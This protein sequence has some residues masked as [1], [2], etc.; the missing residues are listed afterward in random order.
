MNQIHTDLLTSQYESDYY[1]KDIG[2][3]IKVSRG[4]RQELTQR[5]N[6][7][8]SHNLENDNIKLLDIGCGTGTFLSI[9]QEKGWRVSG[10]ELS[11]QGREISRQRIGKENVHSN[12]ELFDAD[13]TFDIIT[14]WDVIEHIPTPL[15]ELQKIKNLL[16]PNGLFALTTPNT[17]AW[18]K[19]FFHKKWR[20]F[21]A[22]EHI[23]YFNL[24][25]L[26]TTLE[27][28]GFEIIFTQTYYSDKAFWQFWG[29]DGQQFYR[30]WQ[31]IGTPI[32]T[33]LHLI[34]EYYGGGD[35]LEIIARRL[36]D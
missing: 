1:S 25:N 10:T 31:F 26:S 11:P 19:K 28:L 15:N 9:A 8:A 35:N 12:L 34:A 29:L 3:Y 5:L 18:N 4:Q 6:R 13:A 7:L 23:V 2:R 17:K 22:P 33:P 24:Q 20:Y 21:I 32:L 36:P 30:W 27:Q 14:M 16:K